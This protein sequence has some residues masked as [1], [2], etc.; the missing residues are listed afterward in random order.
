MLEARQ[1]KQSSLPGDFFFSYVTSGMENYN[2]NYKYL[3]TNLFLFY[4]QVE[5]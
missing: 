2:F 5:E 3:G 4:N 1:L